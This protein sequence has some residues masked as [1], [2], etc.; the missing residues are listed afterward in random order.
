MVR[1]LF[2]LAVIAALLGCKQP[3]EF[4]TQTAMTTLDQ[5]TFASPNNVQTLTFTSGGEREPRPLALLNFLY[6]KRWL[7]CK[8]AQ[9]ESSPSKAVC[10]LEAAGRIYARANGWAQ[11]RAARTCSKCE[12]WSVPVAAAKLQRVLSVAATNQTQAAATYEYSVVP[13]ELGTQLADYMARNPAAW[14]GPIPSV[15]GG[16]FTPRSGTTEFTRNDGVWQLSQPASGFASTFTDPAATATVAERP[17]PTATVAAA[18]RHTPAAAAPVSV[19]TI[20]AGPISRAPASITP[21]RRDHAY[22]LVGDPWSCESVNGEPSTQRYIS[23]AEGS[24][25]LHDD[26]RVAKHSYDIVETYRFDPVRGLWNTEVRGGGYAG[27]AAPWAHEKWIFNGIE[28]ERGRHSEVR[29]VYTQ[30][31]EQAYR[32]DFQL[33]SNGQTFVSETCKRT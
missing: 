21:R 17:C 10:T 24:I 12:T 23:D 33:S 29:M 15:A 11:V 1:R 18:P 26:V 2:I 32:R 3:G 16:W 8:P 22:A 13:T 28:T 9:P 25:T 27:T 31:G 4:V 7:S 20:S 30:L 19:A 5:T 14:C 6:G